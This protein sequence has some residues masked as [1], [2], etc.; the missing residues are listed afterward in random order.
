MPDMGEIAQT[1]REYTGYRYKNIFVFPPP[2]MTS[3]YLKMNRPFM[4]AIK[5]SGVR[6]SLG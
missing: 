5:L 3:D 1:L 6:S 4:L 2:L